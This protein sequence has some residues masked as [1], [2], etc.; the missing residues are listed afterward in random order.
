MKI[1]TCT[2][3]AL[4]SILLF[5]GCTTHRASEHPNGAVE[6]HNKQATEKQATV[7]AAVGA[8][9]ICGAIA[10]KTT[11]SKHRDTATVLSATLCGAAAYQG[12]KS[13]YKSEMLDR[14]EKH[15]LT[16]A[17]PGVSISR[18]DEGQT[19]SVVFEGP[20]AN[21]PGSTKI[22]SDM[23][24]DIQFIA[25]TL[26]LFPELKALVA[27]AD[28]GDTDFQGVGYKRARNIAK[29]LYHAKAP[30]GTVK[31]TSL[32]NSPKGAVTQVDFSLSSK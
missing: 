17:K 28:P 10:N 19:I 2:L 8:A 11:S 13:G 24:D 7:G 5:S 14:A 18:S 9:A 29:L 25:N 21:E 27:T 20:W 16:I 4:S 3:L 30:R 15:L 22:R 6:R 1:S 26:N 31:Y 12:V 23:K 32:A